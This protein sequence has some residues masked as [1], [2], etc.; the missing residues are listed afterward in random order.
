MSTTANGIDFEELEGSPLLE[1]N[2]QG[3]TAT[4]RFRIAWADYER[5]VAELAGVS[6]DVGGS[7]VVSEPL[8]FPGRR[9]DLQVDGVRIEPFD[10]TRPDGAELGTLSAGANVYAGGARVTVTYRQRFDRQNSAQNKK[11]PKPP[12][13]TYLT[14]R[15]DG[16]SDSHV[17]PGRHWIWET[18][19]TDLPDDQAPA[20]LQPAT[21]HRLTWHHVVRPPW[22][23]LRN[24]L[25][26]VNQAE[27]LGADAETLL[28]AGYSAQH[29]FRF[30][31]RTLVWRLD[32][33][34]SELRRRLQAGSY[35]GWNFGYN[36][37]A[38]GGE[39]WQ[40]IR[41]KDSPVE[42]PYGTADLATILQYG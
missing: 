39:H 41:T 17:V 36:K 27:F 35:A 18:L 37:Q 8:A 9:D 34:F 3:I 16:S 1:I 15:C 40:K 30:N 24:A 5:F 23:A 42:Y 7:V 14:Y 11:L 38:S 2:Q 28:F 13:G 31:E 6:L 21:M 4:R 33:T 29:Y 10:P 25:G 32:Y 26:R 20:I 22:T 12:D 19:G